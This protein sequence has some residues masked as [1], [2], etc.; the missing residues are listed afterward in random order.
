MEITANEQGKKLLRYITKEKKDV[1]NIYFYAVLNGLVLLSIPLGIQ[2][3]VSFVMGAT[4]TTSIYILIFFVVIGTWLAGY[5]RL[6]V[7]Q[8]I[9]KIQQ[10]IYVEFSIAIAEKIPKVDLSY[11]RKYYLPELVNRFFDIQN[12]QKGISK[13]LLEIPTALIQIAFGILLLSFY[14]PWFLAF[15]G[16][17]IISVVIIF[18][19]TMESGI[20]SSIEESNKKYDTAAWIED[21]A[22]SVKTF[23]MYSENDAHLKGTDDRVVEYL[24]HRTSHFKVLVFQYKTIIAFKVIITLAMLAIGTY[25]LINQ[26]LNIGAFIATEIVVLSIMSAVEKLIVS[27]ESYYDLIASFAKLSKITELKEEPNGEIVLSQKEKGTE[28]EFKN[29]SFSFNDHNPI[30]SD[31]NFKIKENS[32]TLLT[33]KLGSGKTL[34]LN[35]ITGFFEPS[36]GTI[37][38]DKIPLKNIEKQQ[39]RNHIGLYLENM[40]IIQ[41]TVKEN[42]TL[43]NTESH[44]EDILELSENIGIENISSM[45]SSG[46]FTEVS[47]TDP[48][49]TFSS[50]KK[51]LLLRALLGEKRLII[52]ENPFAGIREEY[53]YKMIEYL[54]KVKEKTTIIIVSQDPELL[55]YADQHIHLED[56]TSKTY[57]KNQ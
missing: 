8:I 37:L 21:I 47:E 54:Q 35:M 56:S 34:L 33:G 39:L 45:F 30:L 44:T 14:H 32:I 4:M 17:V 48:E 19:Y 25:L 23:K 6:K 53:Q 1:T 41:G 36:S 49:I 22:G 18:R 42:I 2:S 31:L 28:I 50:K 15:G 20:K 52:L 57:Y 29:V 5:F 46:F 51:I 16:L 3:I 24:K 13:I 12:L 10:K 38:F 7:I 27:L 11:T 9:E 26:K 40:K 43:G 55:Q